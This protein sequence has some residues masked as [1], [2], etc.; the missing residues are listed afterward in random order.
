MLAKPVTGSTT[1]ADAV[2][3]PLSG[4]SS[5]RP[6]TPIE[7]IAPPAYEEQGKSFIPLDE[8]DL[9]LW[10]EAEDVSL[11]HEPSPSY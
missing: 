1:E 2:T 6:S 5:P 10:E 8:R 3:K 7:C 4:S 9:E 11:S